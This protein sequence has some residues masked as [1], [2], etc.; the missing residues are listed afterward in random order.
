MKK[1]KNPEH[2]PAKFENTI[3]KINFTTFC[4]SQNTKK[5]LLQKY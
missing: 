1:E 2:F 4:V 5:K 3:E